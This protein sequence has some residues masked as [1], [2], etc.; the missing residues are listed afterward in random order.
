MIIV[1]NWKAYVDTTEKAKKLF[2]SAKRLTQYADIVLAMPHPYI[3]MCGGSAKSKVALAA[4]D[5]SISTGGADTGEVTAG[6]LASLGVSY[7]IVGHSE[8]RAKGETDE[9]VLEKVK[10]ALAHNITPILCVG[11]QE[12]DPD[13]K[14]LNTVRAQLSAVF[15]QLS[16]KERLAVVVAYEPIWAI[17]KTAAESIQ[18]VDLE[19]MVLYIRKVLGE[20][21]PGKS[22]LKVRVIY[23]GS[24]EPGNARALAGGSGIDGFLVGHASVDVPTFSAL[25]RAVS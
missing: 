17:G 4:Q 11:E 3:G 12:R 22:P 13:A 23:G 9:M 25:V 20:Y 8:R 1:A 2:T 14:Y 5:V 21:L 7:A 19:E 6:T 16:Q 10:R 18:P 15:S 24:A